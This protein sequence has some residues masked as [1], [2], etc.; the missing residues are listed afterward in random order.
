MSLPDLEEPLTF[1]EHKDLDA[2]I[3]VLE[4]KVQELPAHI[5][6]HLL[7]AR[8]Y[9]ARGDWEQALES[10]EDVH[11]LMPNSPVA[12]EGKRRV[13]RRMDAMTEAPTDSRT[14][15]PVA[16]LSRTPLD[17]ETAPA[18]PESEE[19]D[20]DE[21]EVESPPV[22]AED[23]DKP[24]EEELEWLRR[25]AEHEARRGGAR[26]G[27]SRAPLD[28]PE[29]SIEDPKEKI[30]ELDEL[31]SSR[32]LER[33]ID[34]LESARIEP[35]PDASSAPPP[36]LD[37]TGDDVVSETLAR[38]HENQGNLEEAARI[39]R[40]LA[41]EEPDRADEFEARATELRDRAEGSGGNA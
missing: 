39:Y 38:I 30:E 5:V 10:W 40:R 19:A 36:D 8:S 3:E 31:E 20:L 6:A 41:T 18:E 37:D 28:E 25:Q 27:L 35:D 12:R 4:H 9:E 34:E 24:D 13:M 1:L 26:P 29:D 15:P 14:E 22:E 33:L 21:P 7:L 11:F 32:D 16:P 17:D 2:A 23:E